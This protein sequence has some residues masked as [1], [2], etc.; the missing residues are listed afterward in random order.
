M[1][2]LFQLRRGVIPAGDVHDLTQ[3]RN[4]VRATFELD[5]I[6]GY[7][8]GALLG[9]TYGLPLVVSIVKEYTDLPVIY[10]HQKAGTDIPQLGEKFARVCAEAGIRG[11][12]IFPQAGPETETAFIDALV[13]EG[14]IPMVGGEMTHPRYMAKDGGFIRDNAPLEIY[15]LAAARGVEHFILPGTKPAM[16][17][18]YHS[19]LSSLVKEPKYSMPGIGRQGGE[20]PAAFAAVGSAPAYA[21][22]GASIYEQADMRSAAQRYCDEALSTIDRREVA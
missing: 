11:V 1:G 20:I 18:R 8:V 5:G 13:A 7:K 16:M 22:I 3:F 2:E 12:I 19:V 15:Q 9:L 4:L 6:V 21:I 10:D 17:N 14:L